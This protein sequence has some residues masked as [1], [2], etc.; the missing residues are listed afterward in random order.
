VSRYSEIILC[1]LDRVFNQG[2]V[3]GLDDD[4][5]LKRFVVERDE[6]AFAALV[7]R[8]GGMVMG[9]CRRILHDEHDVEDA[10]QATF[11]VLVSRAKAIRDG[12]LLGHWIYGV[13]HRVAVRARANA[14]RRYVHEQNLTAAQ[15]GVEPPSREGE[16]RDLVA[17]LDEELTRLPELLRAPMVL[18]YL[19]GL[20]HEEAAGRL[21]WPVGTV[22]SR[23]ARARDK[24][25]RRLSSRGLT[26]DDAT[27]TATVA[28][29]PV[30][31]L[32][33]DATVRASLGFTARQA[34]ATAMAT[35]TA[36]A[37]GVLHAMMISKLTILG[38]AML[39]CVLALGGM[40][41]YA[42]QFGGAGEAGGPAAPMPPPT[43]ANDRQQALFR[44]VAK[45]QGELAES[46][47][48]NAELQKELNELRADLESQRHPAGLPAPS[49]VSQPASSPAAAQN[50]GGFAGNP[51]MAGFTDV[52]G[53]AGGF[54]GSMGGM[55]GTM[56][57][58]VGMGGVG[59]RDR[60]R[61]IQTSQL[62]VV[63]SPE[64]DTVTGYST[65]TGK[66]KS[67]RLAKARDTKLAVMPIV[68][69]G[70]AAL[71]LKG[72]KITR[73]AAFSVLDG[74]WYAQDLREPVDKAWPIVGPSMAAYGIGRRIYAFSP[75]AKRWD[76]LELP[77]GAVAQPAIGSDAI[78]CTHNGH[79]YVF[80]VKTGK[81]E[82]IDTRAAP[83]DQ[84][85]ERAAK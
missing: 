2:T 16:R 70:L 30:S 18:C 72:P 83:D 15:A 61:T 34:T 10:F 47:R 53:P 7:A 6:V 75:V 52:V 17:V 42:L 40:H 27:L 37:K 8:H 29:Q 3:A 68:S 66:A 71:Y 67:L 33:I 38:A 78:T 77:E 58:P 9:V 82:D 56:T 74:T 20:T 79:L 54:G 57:G 50:T 35:A 55:S 41:S 4:K 51:P 64:G 48:I 25:R 65:E 59:A 21:R 80:S 49:K 36:L 11:L 31:S 14:A 73:I 69:Q 22:R 13:A 12:G 43:Q 28:S 76:V 1:Q 24:L 46:A 32:L 62:I 60:L 44:S 45:I 23:L 81:W 19:E 39:T 63:S 26:A 84:D 85:G 5:L